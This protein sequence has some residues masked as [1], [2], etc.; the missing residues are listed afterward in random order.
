MVPQTTTRLMVAGVW[1]SLV[2]AILAGA[3]VAGI[4]MPAAA[5]L[6]IVTCVAPPAVLLLVWRG[7]PPPTIAETIN[8]VDRRR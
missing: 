4:S 2:A 8:A 6:L 7:G 1:L 5:G 3:A